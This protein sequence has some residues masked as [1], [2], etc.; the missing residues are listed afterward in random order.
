MSNL[1]PSVEK[2]KAG[3]GV[4]YAHLH[5]VPVSFDLLKGIRDYLNLEYQWQKI[6]TISDLRNISSEGSDY[7]YL[8]NQRGEHFVSASSNIPSQ[9]FRQVIANFLGIPDNFDWKKFPELHNIESTL[10]LL[11]PSEFYN[12]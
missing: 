1:L 3:C 10:S 12:E 6:D 9:L 7:L 11:H 5:L 8:R 2:S 4:D